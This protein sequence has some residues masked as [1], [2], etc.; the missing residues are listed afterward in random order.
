MSYKLVI[1]KPGFNVLTA[2]PEQRHFD[3]DWDS[4]KAATIGETSLTITAPTLDGQV[5]IAHGMAY[6]PVVQVLAK[7]YPAVT[8]P[9]PAW[10]LLPYNYGIMDTRA[11]SP[12]IYFLV[13]GTNITIKVDRTTGISPVT[14][15]T[16]SFKYYVFHNQL[17]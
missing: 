4:L 2:T 1:S 9:N 14:T 6:V 5:I 3:S 7:V 10:T 11:E 12:D 13:D 15:D 8:S 16:F 17:N